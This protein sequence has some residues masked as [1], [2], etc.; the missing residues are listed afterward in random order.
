MFTVY[1]PDVS[2]SWPLDEDR[3]AVINENLVELERFI[4]VDEDLLVA[5]KSTN[6]FSRRQLDHISNM[7]KSNR[8]M[9]LLNMLKRRSAN[10]FSQFVACLKKT[11]RHLV[12]LL[13]A[14]AGD[15]ML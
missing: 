6:C 3:V 12:P 1:T 8:N 14:N 11:Q 5:M 13:T 9:E 7:V 4:D 10:R 2:D 15:F